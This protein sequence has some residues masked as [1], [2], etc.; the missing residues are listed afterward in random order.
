M[1]ETAGLGRRITGAGWPDFLSQPQRRADQ[2]RMKGLIGRPKNPFM[3]RSPLRLPPHRKKGPVRDFLSVIAAGARPS[4]Q[5]LYT[6]GE[7]LEQAL[8]QN[9]RGACTVAK[10]QAWIRPAAFSMMMDSK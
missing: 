2:R 1:R 4:N 9:D 5:A 3:R 8:P 10:D 7:M 6:G